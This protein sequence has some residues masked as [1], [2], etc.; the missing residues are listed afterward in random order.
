MTD[1]RSLWA[2]SSVA[3]GGTFLSFAYAGDV[4]ALTAPLPVRVGA[5][6][7]LREADVDDVVETHL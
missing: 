3:I 7:G 4:R 2:S 1:R 5:R 6:L